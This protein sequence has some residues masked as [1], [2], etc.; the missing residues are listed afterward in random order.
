MVVNRYDA[1]VVGAGPAGSTAAM[2]LAQNNMK[3]ALI[4]RGEHPGSKNMF[5]GSI[6]SMPLEEIIPGFWEDKTCPIERPLITDELWFLDTTSAVKVGFTGLRYGKPPYNNFSAHRSHF[7]KWM[8]NKAVEA[9]AQLINNCTVRDLY[10]KKDGV[11]SK[12]IDGI[13]VDDGDVINSDVV[14]L[15]EGANAAISDKVGLRG[16]MDSSNMTLYV[17]EVLQLD[18]GV[19]EDRF[20]LEKDEGAVLGLIGYPT[21]GAIGKGGIWTYKDSV[22]IIVGAYLN[23]IVEKGLSPYQLMQ[24]TKEHP[25]VKRL[26]K[27]AK[28]LEYQSRIIPKGGYKNIPKLYDDGLIVTGDAAMMISGRRGT[29]LA[30]MTGKYAGEA[31]AQGFAKGDYSKEILKSYEM[32]VNSSFFM[33]DIKG[34]KKVES[35]YKQH[36]DADY[37]INKAVNDAAYKFFQV[38]MDTTSQ[39]NKKI[40]DEIKLMQPYAK[41]L[42]DVLYGTKHWGVY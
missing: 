8:G 39:K 37:L 28:V 4:E 1:V 31:V 26:I 40:A 22:A 42:T 14:I 3:V 13:I 33:Q 30:M 27:G 41:T 36:P 29:D 25:L 6:Y 16:K 12:K 17:R 23:Q 15:C 21:S 19:I 11:T 7:D 34:G 20:N 32:R 9:G 35:Y 38:D 10:Y 18:R 2:M 5:G 24:Q